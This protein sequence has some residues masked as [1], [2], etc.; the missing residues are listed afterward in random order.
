MSIIVIDPGHGGSERAGRSTPWGARGAQGTLEKD[1][2]LDI[3]RR[4]AARLGG[5]AALTREGDHNVSLADRA[6]TA[7]RLGARAFISLHVGAGQGGQGGPQVWIHPATGL[8]SRALA[9]RLHERLTAGGASNEGVRCADLALLGHGVLPSATAG[10]LI[11]VGDLGEG[12][13][14]LRDPSE[15]DRIA[16]AIAAGIRDW[17]AEWAYGTGEAEQRVG[18]WT[19][20]HGGGGGLRRLAP[21][22][23]EDAFSFEIPAGLRF[24]RWEVIPQQQSPG[25]GY[26][27]RVAPP[28]GATGTQRCVVSWH[29]P[30]AGQIA[31]ELRVYASFDGRAG[32]TT[33]AA[34][35]QGWDHR[36]KDQIQQG[37]PITIELR[38]AQARLLSGLVQRKAREQGIA[39][40][41][42]ASVTG[43]DDAVI[44]AAIV[45]LGVAA[46]AALCFIAG[47][48]LVGFVLKTA[49]ENGYEIIDASYGFDTS[50]G[51]TP[52]EDGPGTSGSQGHRLGFKLRKRQEGGE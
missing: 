22:R 51:M 23:G 46:I 16:A 20:Q 34:E 48:V 43:V 33:V 12:E 13:R 6:G 52:G 28:R 40:H 25:A 49:M 2:T 14:R 37:V 36:A 30:P 1:V 39:P 10:C 50:S 44:V 5:R 24:S 38:G 3:A 11:E 41:A 21:G 18:S 31:Y 35:G 4:V 42:S 47:L 7:H 32:E 26:Q 17:E 9:T 15:L 27:M 29:L 8:G 45:V 19:R